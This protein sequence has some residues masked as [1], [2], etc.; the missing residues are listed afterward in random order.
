MT[1]DGKVA[2][3]RRLFR[4]HTDVRII[5]VVN[6]AIGPWASA[7]PHVLSATI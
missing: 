1:M 7:L 6:A 4:G 3:F 5:D 2:L